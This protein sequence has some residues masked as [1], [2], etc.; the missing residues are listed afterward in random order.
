MTPATSRKNPCLDVCSARSPPE[1]TAF[2]DSD[3]ME[4]VTSQV[5]QG[6]SWMYSPEM[7]CEDVKESFARTLRNLKRWT[8][9]YM[10]VRM[11]M[12]GQMKT[13]L[14]KHN[15]GANDRAKERS[16]G[17]I[18]SLLGES[19]VTESQFDEDEAERL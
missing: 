2:P 3:P 10:L 17:Q 8:R 11:A 6:D 5:C 7:T 18:L 15:K 16:R 12:D 13:D 4:D 19:C 9:L 1:A 14:V